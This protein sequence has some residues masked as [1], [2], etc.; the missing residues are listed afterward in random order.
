[1]ARTFVNAG[2]RR[3]FTPLLS[4]KSGDLVYKD[5]FYGVMQDDAAF[6]SG[7]G[8]AASVADRPVVQIL[9][10]VWDLKANAFDA[11]AI[12][13]GV[14]VYAQPTYSATTLLLYKN[15]ASLGA[16]VVAIG[17]TWATALAGASLIR[18]GLFAENDY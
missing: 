1:M 11:S 5:G 8:A 16:S 17:R 14:K 15:V 12:G 3:Q 10:G 4:H 9:D 2:R 18:V 6:P 7:T 13:P